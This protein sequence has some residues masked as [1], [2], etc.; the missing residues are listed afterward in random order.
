MNA[1]AKAARRKFNKLA[2]LNS[3]IDSGG[4][5][6]VAARRAKSVMNDSW[7]K[8]KSNN[9]KGFWDTTKARAS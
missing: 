5:A 8:R 3:D 6:G 9:T 2:K 1:T 4:I 7:T